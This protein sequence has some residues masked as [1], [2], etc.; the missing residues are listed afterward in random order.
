MGIAPEDL[1]RIFDRGF[2]GY[3]GRA[4]KKATGLGLYLCRQAAQRLGV[5]ITA[6]SVVGKGSAFYMDLNVERLEVE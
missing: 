3:N 5:T 2:T 1:P 6:E 4:D